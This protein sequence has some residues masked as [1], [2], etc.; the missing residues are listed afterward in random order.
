[1]FKNK[2]KKI[3][4]GSSSI[5]FNQWISRVPKSFRGVKKD[6]NEAGSAAL[7]GKAPHR[8]DDWLPM[9]GLN[10]LFSAATPNKPHGID[11]CTDLIL[12]MKMMGRGD[13]IQ[14]RRKISNH[15]AQQPVL[16]LDFSDTVF[17]DTRAL[18]TLLWGALR[19][20][21]I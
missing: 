21:K 11:Y 19:P 1:M 8:V 6:T 4:V 13:E 2:Y 15:P 18:V 7:I 3:S 20:L 10:V 5:L 17:L 16:F 9:R 12:D 14:S